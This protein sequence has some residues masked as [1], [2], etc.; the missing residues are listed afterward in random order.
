MN[1]T[2][3]TTG[4]PPQ[5]R[6]SDDQNASVV[7]SVD[8]AAPRRTDDPGQ[9]PVASSRRGLRR[10]AARYPIATFLVG[11]LS[12]AYALMLLWGL[13][14]TAPSRAD[15]SPTS[16]ASPQT[17]WPDSCRSLDSSRQRSM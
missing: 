12:M 13:A 15:R 10:L 17:S 7:V 2:P 16:C 9:R 11:G 14:Y 4:A 1:H 8:G 3:R 5:D 6:Q